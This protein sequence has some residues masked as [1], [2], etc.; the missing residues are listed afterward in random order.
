MAFFGLFLAPDKLTAVSKFAVAIGTVR[1]MRQ[2]NRC[3]SHNYTYCTILLISL[4]WG[5]T[6]IQ[7]C[8]GCEGAHKCVCVCVCVCVAYLGGL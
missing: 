4:A 6:V 8:E 5:Y 3:Y 1:A 7:L 2:V